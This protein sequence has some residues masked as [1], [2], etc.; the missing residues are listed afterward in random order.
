MY[1]DCFCRYCAY[2][3]GWNSCGFC[4]DQLRLSFH[5]CVLTLLSSSMQNVVIVTHASYRPPK[6][7]NCWGKW[8]Y[9]LHFSLHVNK[10][11]IVMHQQ[12]L[13]QSDWEWE[14]VSEI[15]IMHSFIVIVN[16]CFIPLT[17]YPS[18]EELTQHWIFNLFVIKG[19]NSNDA[20]FIFLS[21][22][23]Y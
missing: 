15:I 1:C 23:P 14:S 22:A 7:S 11:L 5:S 2:N 20:P 17:H 9:Y 16:N 19:I 18:S 10:I 3:T 6:S 21:L 12:T 4:F 13:L 8:G